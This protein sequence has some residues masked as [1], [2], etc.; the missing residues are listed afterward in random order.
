MIRGSASINTG[1][2][3]DKNK[4]LKQKIKFPK[5]FDTKVDMKCINIKAIK[6]WIKTS[7]FNILSFDDDVVVNLIYNM[8]SNDKYPNPKDLSVA[9]MGF[10]ENDTLVKY[11]FI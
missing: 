2:F 6:P 10:L 11:I 9:L 5:I 4:H 3:K 7:V 8:L 1:R